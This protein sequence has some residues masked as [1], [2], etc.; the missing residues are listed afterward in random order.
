MITFSLHHVGH[1]V[2]AIELA[3]EF[4]VQK[5]GY[6]VHTAVI[7][8]TTQTAYVQFLRLPGESA[9]V[10]LVAPDGPQSKLSTAA[11]KGGGLNHLCYSVEDIEGA[12]EHLCKSGMMLLSGPT[13]AVA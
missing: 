10:E 2:A 13:P 9:Y 8:D 11:R 7:H 6:Q 5:L 3:S 1:A 12:V 4:Y